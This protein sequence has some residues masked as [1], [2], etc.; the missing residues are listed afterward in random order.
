MLAGI[1][2]RRALGALVGCA[3]ALVG[4][5]LLTPATPVA[6][7]TTY[8]VGAR[9]RHYHDHQLHDLIEHD[10]HAARRDQC[11]RLA[12]P[13]RSPSTAAGAGRSC[14]WKNPPTLGV[15]VMITGP[16]SGTGV[17]VDGAAR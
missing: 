6:A 11:L 4:W 10:L 13:I 14:W 2:L 12:A 15:I 8:Y 16:T 5:L 3:L 17:I 9:R 7:A 1:P